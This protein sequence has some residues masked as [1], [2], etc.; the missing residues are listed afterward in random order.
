MLN[1]TLFK[2]ALL[3]LIF[4]TALQSDLLTEYRK[5]GI[6]NITQMMDSQLAK[7]EYWS[8]YIKD[9]DT[10]FGY[11]ESYKNILACDKSN[12][13][14]AL[15][16]KDANKTFVLT[17]EYSAFTGKEK[18]DKAREG[19]LKTPVGVYKQTKKLSK[20]DS[21]YGPMAFVT[22]YPNTYDKYRGKNGSGIWIHGLPL[23]QERDSYTK[24]CIAINNPSIECLDRNIDISQTL[25]L[26][27]EEKQ[28]RN[29]SKESLSNI[30]A[31]LYAWRYSWIYNDITSYLN[32][33]DEKFI[34][35]DGMNIKSFTK[36]K[37]RI[38]KKNEKKTIIFNNI[39]II[40]Y[41]GTQNMYKVTFSE[42]YKSNSFSFSGEKVLILKVEDNKIKIITEK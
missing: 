41:P 35:F 6:E 20:V 9:I 15:Y 29:V 8:K 19:D 28:D 25:L 12:S 27:S 21:F 40:P 37:T 33:Y 38:F 1:N 39:N 32:F 26:I 5:H 3:V 30:L 18:G 24:G 42:I 17:K 10:S 23:S 31:Q 16:M 13:T 14:L 4:N 2:L 22:S 11:I 36:Y 34:R 7:E